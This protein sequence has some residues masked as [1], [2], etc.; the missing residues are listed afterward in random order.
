MCA[1]IH[2][3]PFELFYLFVIFSALFLPSDTKYNIILTTQNMLDR[4]W[5]SASAEPILLPNAVLNPVGAC[6]V[7]KSPCE[8][9]HLHFCTCISAT[10][11][12]SFVERHLC[13]QKLT[14]HLHN[15][16][17]AFILCTTFQVLFSPFPLFLSQQEKQNKLKGANA[18]IIQI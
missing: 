5:S 17:F 9:L 16:G 6:H 14:Y 18:A 3:F 15:L 13:W 12:H 7:L 11:M 4:R 1:Y 10:F 2:I 8:D